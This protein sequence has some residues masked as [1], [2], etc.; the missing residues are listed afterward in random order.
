ML[1]FAYGSNLDWTQMKQRCPSARF[2]SIAVLCGHRLAFTRYS[3]KRGCG[4]ADAVPEKGSEVWGVVYEISEGDISSL[5]KSE[6]Y[7]PGRAENAYVR[8]EVRVLPDGLDDSP[9]LVAIYFVCK[10]PNLFLPGKEYKDLILNGARHWKLPEK[11]IR[12]VLEPI[13][14]QK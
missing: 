10:Q 3:T 4:V 14:V 2:Y 6:D 12:S 1:Y 11:Y 8:E 7:R 9:Q 13:G 5:D